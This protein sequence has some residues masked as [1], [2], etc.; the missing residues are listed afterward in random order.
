VKFYAG[1]YF[2]S[3]GSIFP[4]EDIVKLIPREMVSR[5]SA[6]HCCG[7][8][9]TFERVNEHAVCSSERLVLPVEDIV[10]LMKLIPRE[11]VSHQPATAAVCY[12]DNIFTE[13]VHKQVN[14]IP[15]LA[16]KQFAS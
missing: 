7:L 5:K 16:R 1:K 4:V 12:S 9:Q 6:R 3:F 15:P 11:M 8:S 13:A 10:K 14:A 2:P